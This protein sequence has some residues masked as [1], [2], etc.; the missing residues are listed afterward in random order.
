LEQLNAFLIQLKADP[1]LLA[2]LAATR[3]EAPELTP[4]LRF[5]PRDSEKWLAQSPP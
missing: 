2:D 4:V 1:M 5:P 3:R